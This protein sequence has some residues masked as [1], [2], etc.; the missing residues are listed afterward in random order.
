MDIK[1]FYPGET[2]ILLAS[3]LDASKTVP[4]S[5]EKFKQELGKT[6]W[7]PMHRFFRF[8]DTMRADPQSHIYNE[9]VAQMRQV[10]FV[11]LCENMKRYTSE[12]NSCVHQKGY[13][14]RPPNPKYLDP[15]NQQIQK[16]SAE[17]AKC[18]P[19]CE[20]LLKK[21]HFAPYDVNFHQFLA[22]HWDELMD[23][24][25]AEITTRKSSGVLSC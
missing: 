17:L 23:I 1:D 25:K 5:L 20:T 8:L 24:R 13:F 9:E 18:R 19:E 7:G 11:S 12:I 3:L 22:E 14:S 10:R 4:S 16:A 21:M 6:K 15:L 2:L